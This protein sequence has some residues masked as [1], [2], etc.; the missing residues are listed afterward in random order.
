[1]NEFNFLLA[2]GFSIFTCLAAAGI[3]L[4]MAREPRHK[5]PLHPAPGE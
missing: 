3:A 4:W 5:R 1:M 2:F